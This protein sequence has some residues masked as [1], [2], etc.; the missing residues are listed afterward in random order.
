MLRCTELT[1]LQAGMQGSLQGEGVTK[2]GLIAG[3]EV[4]Q[5]KLLFVTWGLELFP[6]VDFYFPLRSWPQWC[7]NPFT[8]RT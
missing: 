7:S 3:L 8:G 5:M 1:L 4:H 6:D 2:L